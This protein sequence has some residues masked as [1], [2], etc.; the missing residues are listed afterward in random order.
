[1]M[2]QCIKTTPLITPFR[3][4]QAAG[5][6]RAPRTRS[7]SACKQSPFVKNK[8]RRCGRQKNVASEHS[9]AGVKPRSHFVFRSRGGAGAGAEPTLFFMHRFVN[10][11]HTVCLEQCCTTA[12]ISLANI[13]EVADE[14]CAQSR[15]A[16]RFFV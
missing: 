1:M 13:N 14:W 2:V 10:Y 12:V 16:A 4:C 11:W 5:R 15:N 8:V 7:P 3:R 9:A 6:V